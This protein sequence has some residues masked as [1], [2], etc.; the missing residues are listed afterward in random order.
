M[1][2][3]AVRP[4][5]VIESGLVCASSTSRRGVRAH[6]FFCGLKAFAPRVEYSIASFFPFRSASRRGTAR[7]NKSSVRKVAPRAESRESCSLPLY[8]LPLSALAPLRPSAP[9]QYRVY[10][11][12]NA[13]SRVSQFRSARPSLPS[14][15]SCGYRGCASTYGKGEIIFIPTL[16]LTKIKLNMT[17]KQKNRIESDRSSTIEQLPSCSGKTGKHMIMSIR[18]QHEWQTKSI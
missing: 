2:G 16:E 18:E 15:A 7:E 5:V 1:A 6:V 11:L 9:K 8:V 3:R 14:N 13:C 4:K 17:T 12:V 10:H